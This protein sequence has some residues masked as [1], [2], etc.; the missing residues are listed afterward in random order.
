[1][2]TDSDKGVVRGGECAVVQEDFHPC[3]ASPNCGRSDARSTF[4][5]IHETRNMISRY[6][7]SLNIQMYAINVIFEAAVDA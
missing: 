3:Y 2:L 4:H 5:S 6:V 1:M 7:I